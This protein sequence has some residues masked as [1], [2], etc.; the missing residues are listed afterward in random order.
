MRDLV[1][2]G[3]GGF[4]RET[5]DTVL[6][7]NEV[8]LTWRI[9]GVVDDSLADVNAQRLHEL[10]V[11]H[12]GG[13][14]RIPPRT[15]VA[16]AVGNPAARR[17]ISMDLA[18][19]GHT[20]PQLIHP[21]TVIGSRFQAGPGLITL[22][23]VSIGTNVQLGDHVHLNAH[24]VIGHDAVLHDHVSVNPNATVSGDCLIGASTLVGAGSVVLQQLSVGS[25][26]TIG[27]A[28]CVTSDVT[29]RAVVVG[30]PA[31]TI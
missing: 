4:G 25:E 5:I 2:V 9:V 23:G 27:A 29:P 17:R 20:F 6:A 26:A 10:D 12:L 19:R 22:A 8:A 15:E 16:I 7:I 11:E 21:T 3:A 1:L 24:A 14:S 30:V 31:R 13:L 28:A 18:R